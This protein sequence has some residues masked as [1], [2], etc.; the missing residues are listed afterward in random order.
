M[1]Q[2]LP[3]HPVEFAARLH[4]R[5]VFI[6]PFIGGNGRAA[7][8]LMNTALTQDGYMLAIIPPVLRQEYIETL[9]H[10]HKD[11]GPFVAFI[12]EGVYETQKEIMKLLYIPFPGLP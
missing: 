9:E 4:K 6:H 10:T 1:Q 11:D 3:F 8:L 7:R 2:P 12:A 5:F